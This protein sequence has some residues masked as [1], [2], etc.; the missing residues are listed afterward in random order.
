MAAACGGVK[1]SCIKRDGEVQRAA[2]ALANLAIIG[3]I[4]SL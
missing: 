2:F 4:P 1:T 3:I